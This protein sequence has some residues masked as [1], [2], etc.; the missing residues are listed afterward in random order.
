MMRPSGSP[1][2]ALLRRS[3]LAVG[4][5]L[6]LASCASLTPPPP[7]AFTMQ[8]LHVAD[9]DGSDTITLGSV[10]NLSGLIARFRAEMPANTLTV[11]SG[12]NYVPGPRFNASGDL[13]LAPL[14]GTPDVG[15]ADIAFLNA[16]GI[17]A[18]ALGNH[19]LDLGPLQ[20][21]NIINTAG[22]GAAAWQGAQFPYLA[23]NVNFAPES[24]LAPRIA[25][26]G[27]TASALANKVSGWVK[28][29]VGGET[30]G[31]I[32]ASSPVFTTISSTGNLAFSP[33]QTGGGNF[34]V[35]ALAANLQKGVDEIRAAGI[36]KV[37]LLA[38]MQTI[39]VERQLATLL[40][41]VDIIVAGGS[42]TL[43]SDANDMLRPG[44]VSAGP[45]P[46]LS[47]SKSGEPVAIVN[48]DA[49]YKYLGR[50]IAPFDAKGVLL[51]ALFDSNKSGAYMT[52]QGNDSAGGVQPNARVVQIR[53]ALAGVIRQQDSNVQGATSVFLEGRRIAVRNQETNFGNLTADANLYYAQQIDPGVQISL[54]NGGG[55]RSEIGE[56]SAPAGSTDAAQV[57]FTPP[58]GN[59]DAKRAVGEV[60][61]LAI[62]SALRFNNALSLL[63]VSAEQLKSLLEHGVAALGSQGRFPQVGGMAFSY[64]PAGT[65]QVIN[66][67]GQVTTPGS[68]IRSLR[69]GNDVLVRDGVLL[70][71][72]RRTFRLVTLNF[73]ADGGDGYPFGAVASQA[74]RVN[75][76]T[77]A[78][79]STGGGRSGFAAPG[80]EQ[81]AL[82]EYLQARFKAPNAPF[83][84]AETPEALDVRIQNT[85]RRAD[86]VLAP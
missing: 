29:S 42:N 84:I 37:V 11:S 24:T 85:A 79:A 55:I 1:L 76:N 49:D 20:F 62:S 9:A 19:E 81:D 56:I 60:S 69:I 64:D 31:V 13:S 3:F 50:L 44:D 66:A 21:N 83:A 39:T 22:T 4:A 40:D 41:G 6:L 33:A 28:I 36:N 71:D 34:D 53:D 63:D 26:N 38:H 30:I 78:T 67:T 82:G 52:A 51:P 16:M 45:Y 8:L 15:R 2:P 35:A 17:Q 10:A 61:Q 27:G 43:L 59:P 73:M 77:V 74:R 46:I 68:R 47:K 80:T 7:A 32:G 72:A 70:G 65:A 48:V 58:S 5:G 75:L 23:Y 86:T 12:D 54:K 18:S 57:R 14:L 25:P